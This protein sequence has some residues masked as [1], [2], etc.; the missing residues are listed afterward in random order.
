MKSL[1]KQKIQIDIW[2]GLT[3]ATLLLG[4]IGTVGGLIFW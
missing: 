2:K 4:V 1:Q 3:V